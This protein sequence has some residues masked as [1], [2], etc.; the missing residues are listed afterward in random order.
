MQRQPRRRL[1][2]RSSRARPPTCRSRTTIPGAPAQ[3][4]RDEDARGAAAAARGPAARKVGQHVKYD[5]HVLRRHGIDVARHAD[6]TMLE[7]YVLELRPHAPRHGLL[8][9]AL[10]RL[11]HRS[12]TRTS[13]AR[14]RSRSRS[15]RWRSTTPPSTPPRTPTSPCACTACCRRSSSRNPACSR[16]REIEH[17]AGAG[18]GADGAR[19]VLID[20]RRCC[21]SRAR[22]SRSAWPSCE[23]AGH[24]VGRRSRSTSDSPKQLQEMLFDELKLPVL[25]KTPNGPAFDQRGRAGGARRPARTAAADPRVPRPREAAQSPTPTSCRS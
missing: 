17:A 10:S 22:T 14:A 5:L 19:G 6:D 13:P 3:L 24:A 16:L 9:E 8:R 25:G 4:D 11:R 20:A 12:S 23:A 18:A 15:P 7:S 2:L 21:A 1:V